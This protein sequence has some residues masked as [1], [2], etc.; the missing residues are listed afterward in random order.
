MLSQ[1]NE[2]SQYLRGQLFGSQ[3]GSTCIYEP[4]YIFLLSSCTCI[5]EHSHSSF[6]F[7]FPAIRMDIVQN[8]DYLQLL[9]NAFQ[10]INPGV[11]PGAG[12]SASG[13]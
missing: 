3:R 10:S 7:P 4:Y 8:K 13:I 1:L 12:V 2:V 5:Y 11:K 9:L 6:P